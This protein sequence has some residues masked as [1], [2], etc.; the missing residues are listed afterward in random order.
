[1][2][3]Y[4]NKLSD[5]VVDMEE[6][7]ATEIAQEIIRQGG[8]AL[9]AIELGLVGGMERV[10]KLYEN[11]E[12]FIPELLMCA[13]A[14]YAGLHVL[15]PH[16]EKEDQKEKHKIVIG[17]ILGDTHDIGKNIVSL[18]LE[19]AGFEVHDLGRDVHPNIF[20]DKA[21]EYEAEIII[22]STLMTTTMKNMGGVIKVL[23]ERNIRDKFKVLVGGRPISPAFAK[24]IGADG[25]SANAASALRLV[26]SLVDINSHIV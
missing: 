17:S 4:Y 25:Y 16:V 22:I 3:K 5:A 26:K 8:N 2:E 9:E 21:V 13:D 12:Y 20:V 14:M 7:L 10:G 19:S 24:E 6:N 11:E 18:I 1:M 15:E 23:K